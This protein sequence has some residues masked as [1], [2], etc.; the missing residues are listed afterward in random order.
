[1]KKH[2][3]IPIFLAHQGCP[4]DCVFCN[5]KIIT[6]KEKPFEVQ[7]AIDRI[8]EY[9]P[10]INRASIE[11][12]EIA[13]FGG[14][15]TGIPVEQQIAYLE[16]AKEYKSKQL[17]DKIRLSTRP[18][19]IDNEIL[20][21]LK[22]YDVDIIEL[23]VQSF[24]ED[25]L[26]LSNRGHDAKCVAE[27]ANL[28]KAHGFELGIQLMIGLPGDTKEK[29]IYSAI[30][31][32]KLKPQISRIYPTIIISNT[33]L[34]QMYN[35]NQYKPLSL[36]EAIDWSKAVYQILFRANINIIRVGLKSSDFI[37]D[38]KDSLGGNF[39]PA[40]R[41]LVESEIAKDKMEAQIKKQNKEIIF[42]SN[43]ES[44]SN[45]VGNKKSNKKYFQEKY[46]Q[47]HFSYKIDSKLED[48][49]YIAELIAD[50]RVDD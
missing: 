6:A 27:S 37:Q 41:Q 25:V 20:N 11:T 4:N 15:F 35:T 10:T 47:K 8:E 39:H 49:E 17:I 31:A 40:F 44:Y 1:M 18:D 50:R 46:P 45:M 14:S 34:E 30:E 24:D 32:V 2:V 21:R 19:Y 29:S 12:V 7:D 23:G 33:E 26:K 38:G 22:E 9:L 36:E 3:I 5:Q 48:Y 43:N 28:I 16:V 13:F 42:Y